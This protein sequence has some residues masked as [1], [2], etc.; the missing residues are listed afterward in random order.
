MSKT[1]TYPMVVYQNA[2]FKVKARAELEA[3]K[4]ALQAL[5]DTWNNSG[6][7][8]I[9]T[10]AELFKLCHTPQALYAAATK[11]D[12]DKA[13]EYKS[14]IAVPLPNEIYIK[15]R[16]A[17][18][19]VY[20]GKVELWSIKDGKVTFDQAAVNAFL[21]SADLVAQN[22][23]Q[24]D[25]IRSCVAFAQASDVLINV[26]TGLPSARLPVWPFEVKEHSAWSPQLNRV[27]LQPDQVKMILRFMT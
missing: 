8:A 1:D 3:A 24:A 25:F 10:Y 18:N 26:L 5:L 23:Q 17:K 22:E 19:Q 21:N 4:A 2:E 20:N 15:A 13:D 11:S 7:P 9:T 14:M 12:A 27:T 6:L 16:A